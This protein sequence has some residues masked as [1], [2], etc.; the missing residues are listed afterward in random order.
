MIQTCLIAELVHDSVAPTTKHR[1]TRGNRLNEETH[2]CQDMLG[3]ARTVVE[4]Q[5][6]VAHEALQD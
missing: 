3:I 5:L 4:W 1:G 6:M 2:R